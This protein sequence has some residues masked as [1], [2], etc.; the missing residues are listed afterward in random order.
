MKREEMIETCAAVAHEANRLF[1]A[2]HGDTSHA[3]WDLAP[4]WQ[5]TSSA[6]GVEKALAGATPEQLHESWCTE[7]RAAGWVHGPVKDADAKTHPCLVPYVELPPE[8]RAKDGLYQR[9]VLAMA[10]ALGLK[11]NE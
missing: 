1:S 2:A 5:R 3:P 10:E 7:K 8:Q 9:V 4:Q 11:S 6:H